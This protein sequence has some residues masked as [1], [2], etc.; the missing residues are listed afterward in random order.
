[1][2]FDSES[3]V[4]LK[5]E[6][7]EADE[8]FR[9]LYQEHQESEQRLAEIDARALSLSLEDES[10]AKRIKLHKLALKDRMYEI[11]REHAATAAV[12]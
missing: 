5:Q 11:L 7:I 4:A 6:L 9:R 2:P 12:A 3:V 1:M 10:E 8:E